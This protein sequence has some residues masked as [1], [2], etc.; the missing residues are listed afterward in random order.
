MIVSIINLTRGKLAD[1]EIQ[2][3]IR[4]INRQIAQDFEPY[5]SFG[6]TL[7]LEGN[8]SNKPKKQRLPDLRGDAVLYL[9]DKID[10][11]DADGYHDTNNRGIPYGFV[12]TDLAVD[13]A[14][15]VT[16]SHEALELMADPQGNLL[17]KGPHPKDHRHKVYHWFEM[18]DAVQDES[19]EIDKVLVANF[20]L[21]HYF[22]ERDELGTR[23]DFLGRKHDGQTL[24]SFG[25]N[26]GGYI[27]F[28]DPRNRRTSQSSFAREGD[29]RAAA[30]RALKRKYGLSRSLLRGRS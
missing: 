6:A 7:R 3:A 20:V 19:Y 26:P 23:N 8:T 29:E 14:W 9:W 21:P 22:T 24:R 30:R 11:A 10:S 18:C 4:A 17:V 1:E 13:P 12:L 15:T 25:V 27:G 28:F 2:R 16:L 5:W